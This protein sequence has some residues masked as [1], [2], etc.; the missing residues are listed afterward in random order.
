MNIYILRYE[1]VMI[2]NKIYVYIKRK[3]KKTFSLI[4]YFVLFTSN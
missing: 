4:V 3:I 1:I 2:V